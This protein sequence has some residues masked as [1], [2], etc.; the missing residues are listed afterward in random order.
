VI[1]RLL[2]LLVALTLCMYSRQAEAEPPVP[3]VGAS[4]AGGAASP[5]PDKG[6][7][8]EDDDEAEDPEDLADKKR[9]Y[10][11]HPSGRRYRVRFDPASRVTFGAGLGV[12]HD[13]EGSALAA[14]EA[15][16]S[17]SYRKVYRFGA[18]ADRI[19]WQIDHQLTS[20]LV[21][22]FVRHAG[23]VPSMDAT[24]YRA[25]LLRHS[26][27]PSIVLPVSPPLTIGFPFDVGLDAELGRVIVPVMPVVLPGAVSPEPWVH[28]GVV[29]LSFTLDPW[30]SGQ[31]GRSLALGVGVRYD[32][33]VYPAPTLE[34][35]RFVHRV[36]PLT[37]GSVRF[38]Y[39]TDDGLLMLDAYGEAAPHWT[40]ENRWDLLANGAVRLDRTLIAL[41][42]LPIGAYAEV[43]YRYLPEGA[44]APALHDV[45]G[46]LGIAASLSLK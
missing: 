11:I 6:K 19:T 15:G 20:G 18:G 1:G 16:F 34:T 13:G 4:A 29:R 45:R 33:D 40:S 46:T 32:V 8:D 43:G 44:G 41:N 2:A 37:S 24:L 42:D 35:P 9:S 10:R 14:F 38:R 7:Q 26:E 39:Q 27:S 12:K 31:V 5:A 22:P 17:F 30:R 3:E 21:R 25:T 23:D 28:L 36:A